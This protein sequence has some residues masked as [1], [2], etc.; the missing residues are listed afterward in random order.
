M[1]I[2]MQMMTQVKMMIKTSVHSAHIIT[3]AVHAFAD[4]Y[5][6]IHH[7]SVKTTTRINAM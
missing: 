3:Q 6:Q 4:A 5:H 2:M 7:L 1:L